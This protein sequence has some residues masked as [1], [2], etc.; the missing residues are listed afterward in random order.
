LLHEHGVI[1]SVLKADV[2]T[3]VEVVGELLWHSLCELLVGHLALGFQILLVPLALVLFVF[4]SLL[5]N[6]W[7]LVIHDKRGQ[8]LH[9]PRQLSLVIKVNENVSDRNQVVFARLL[10]TL[11][12]IF[13]QVPCSAEDPL[14]WH[15]LDVSACLRVPIPLSKAKVD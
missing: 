6:K 15:M 4:D 13:A 2:V 1:G 8:W 7:V 5:V 14:I 10:K 11:V 12:C 3:V 9:I